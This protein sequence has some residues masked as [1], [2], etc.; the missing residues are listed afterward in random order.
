[1]LI[2]SLFSKRKFEKGLLFVLFLME[3][4]LMASWN[5]STT[6]FRVE[7]ILKRF[8]FSKKYIV[9]VDWHVIYLK[10]S[11]EWRYIGEMACNFHLPTGNYKC[12]DSRRERCVS[13]PITHTAAGLEYICA[14]YLRKN[15]KTIAE[16]ESLVKVR[17]NIMQ[18]NCSVGS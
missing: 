10:I 15:C 11:R 7:C 12:H 9:L 16:K 18:S 17:R 14:R 3:F 5:F 6:I 8:Q 1:M 13:L 4:N 2:I